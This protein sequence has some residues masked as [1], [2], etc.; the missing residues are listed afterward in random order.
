M[1]KLLALSLLAFLSAG[2]YAET[3]QQGLTIGNFKDYERI[4][5]PV[6]RAR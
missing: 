5:Y 4:T 1:K 2:V 3:D 6:P